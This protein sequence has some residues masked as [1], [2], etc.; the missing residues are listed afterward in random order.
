MCA[1]GKKA[2][3]ISKLFS[4][5]VFFDRNP[6]AFFITTAGSGIV[7]VNTF[8]E[9]VT[10]YSTADLEGRQIEDILSNRNPA[11]LY[12]YH[13]AKLAHKDRPFQHECW[14]TR[15]DGVDIRVVLNMNTVT[16]EA[17]C[18]GALHDVSEERR[19]ASE[20]AR[21]NLELQKSADRLRAAQE[22]LHKATELATLGEI[23]GR[24][25][26][27]LL[28]PLTA[29]RARIKHL[30]DENAT[31]GELSAFLAE[32]SRQMAEDPSWKSQ[33][34]TLELVGQALNEHRTTVSESLAF[35][36]SEL[37]RIEGLVDGLRSGVV[38]K[39]S[40]WSRYR[41]SDLLEYCREVMAEPLRKAGVSLDISCPGDIHVRGD[42]SEL[43]QI[44]S[45]LVRN[46]V[47]ALSTMPP[48]CERLIEVKAKVK[49]DHVEI[50]VDDTGPGVPEDV[51]PFIFEPNFTTKDSGTGL[52]LAIAKRLA[53][54]HGGDLVL[55]RNKAQGCGFV[56]SLPCIIGPSVAWEG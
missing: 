45:N 54:S 29:V 24:V 18:L 13:R 51:A 2:D 15:K 30:L 49:G 46:A 40:V 25:A 56:L 3:S 23:S 55:K 32:S 41:L 38:K 42:R 33:A 21:Q 4:C 27:E 1:V 35:L 28:N 6:F 10:G 47:E 16:S 8:F 9:Q 53:R 17:F 34:H 44:L 12:S 43:I 36:S 5:E 20:L 14:L 52:G 48:G 7:K 26:H 39:S 19:L 11:D 50:H 31:L 37:A 22:E